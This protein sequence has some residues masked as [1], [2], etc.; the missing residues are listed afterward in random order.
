MRT[1]VTYRVTDGNV[2]EA[3]STDHPAWPEVGAEADTRI[4]EGAQVLY[5]RKDDYPA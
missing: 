2:A 3:S 4:P 1:R 5:W